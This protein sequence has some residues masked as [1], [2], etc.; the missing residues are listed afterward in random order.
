MGHTTS[1]GDAGGPA[2]LR[3]LCAA[4]DHAP[5]CVHARALARPIV[6]C[7][8]FQLEF[9]APDGRDVPRAAAVPV[10]RPAAAPARA[11][12]CDSC[13]SL[14]TCTFPRPPEGAWLCEEYL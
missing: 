2:F 9:M 4:C 5:R 10:R 12:L 8:Q 11:G 1:R 7:E 6:Q 14:G 13:T 3:G